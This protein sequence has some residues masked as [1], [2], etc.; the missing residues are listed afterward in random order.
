MKATLLLCDAA[1]IA[2]GKLYCLGAGW[3]ETG[4][5]PTTMALG[6]LIYVPWDRTNA[7]LGLVLELREA[8]GTVVRL[9]GPAGESPVRIEGG[10]EV[11][12]PPGLARGSSIPVPLAI[13]IAGMQLTPGQRYYWEL[14]IDGQTHEDWTLHFGTR[15]LPPRGGGGPADPTLPTIL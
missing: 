1:Q 9:P 4:P 3:T 8:D 2:E 14:T 7:E 5:G 13:P 12:R 10:F 11:G 6:I 15:P